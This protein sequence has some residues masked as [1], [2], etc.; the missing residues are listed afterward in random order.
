MTDYLKAFIASANASELCTL[1][2][3]CALRANQ[4]GCEEAEDDFMSASEWLNQFDDSGCMSDLADFLQLDY[5][6]RRRNV[7]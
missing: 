1:A 7:A 2:D 6:Q 5:S 3:L 4:L